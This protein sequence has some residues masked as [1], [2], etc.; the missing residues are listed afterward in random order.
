MKLKVKDHSS[1]SPRVHNDFYP[2]RVMAQIPLLAGESPEGAYARLFKYMVDHYSIRRHENSGY[3]L[4]QLVKDSDSMQTEEMAALLDKVQGVN[5]KPVK[6][7]PTTRWR[8]AINVP[9]PTAPPITR[10]AYFGILY[11]EYYYAMF[12]GI[13]GAIDMVSREIDNGN[14]SSFDSDVT[15]MQR[16]GLFPSL[17]YLSGRVYLNTH[18][19]E[20]PAI[21]LRDSFVSGGTEKGMIEAVSKMARSFVHTSESPRRVCT[22]I[23][24]WLKKN[25]AFQKT[26]VLPPTH[27]NLEKVRIEATTSAGI[28]HNFERS[29][30]VIDD[31]II[32]YVQKSDKRTAGP[33]IRILA[34]EMLEKLADQIK[35][36]PN[37]IYDSELLSPYRIVHKMSLKAEVK[38][39]FD[40][41]YK[42]R[43]IFVVSAIKTY[44]DRVA[45][46]PA[47]ERSYGTGANSIGHKWAHGGATRFAKQ[48][49]YEEHH[50]KFWISLDI[51]KFDQ[52]VLASLLMITMFLPWF[53]YDR[54]SEDFKIIE[55]L[56]L[57]SLSNSV[58][59][60]VKWFGEEWKLMFGL[61]FSGELLTSLGDSWYLEVIFD[62]FDMHMNE[63][64][65]RPDWFQ[66]CYRRF[67]DY[68]DDGVLGYDIRVFDAMC[69]DGRTPTVLR[70]YLKIYW[71]MELKMSDTFVSLTRYPNGTSPPHV[72][73]DGGFITV[74]RTHGLGPEVLYRGPKFLKR[75][76]IKMLVNSVP[77]P[78][79][80]RPTTDYFSRSNCISTNPLS[81]PQH[82]IR[83]RA[84][85]LDTYG[86]NERAYNFLFESHEYL[87]ARVDLVN[88]LSVVNRI[89]SDLAN[90]KENWSTEDA[91]L[92]ERIG[93]RD[94]A[95]T[96]AQGFPSLREIREKAAFDKGFQMTVDYEHHRKIYMSAEELAF[97][98]E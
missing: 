57:W 36:T 6:I 24:R 51:S 81:I 69:P 17:A 45:F 10:A 91:N 82:I 61:M 31:I 39:P 92:F 35:N 52:S 83:L 18:K 37:L 43:V 75:Q 15:T 90:N 68:G 49:K 89:L 85:A 67:K 76:I 79:P 38:G 77:E 22:A 78:M 87:M 94:A 12:K 80:W 56:I 65:G 30:N 86:T 40:D 60:V 21:Y 42:T 97:G 1:V 26:P 29:Q 20:D 44:L 54:G 13:D 63:Q 16:K 19:E 50:N 84:L 46:S 41:A 55:Q 59:K 33:A 2:G 71:K 47:M 3:M 28:L 74:I 98:A 72:G 27:S 73:P 5:I 25:R 4:E 53:L 64:L 14:F 95:L 58:V 88:T 66:S 32:D 11:D 62:C 93:G 8:P 23:V 70:D 34:L 7:T 48:F 96:L 9:V